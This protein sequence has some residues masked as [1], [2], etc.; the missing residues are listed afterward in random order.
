MNALRLS[1]IWQFFAGIFPLALTMTLMGLTV[2]LA[3][4][5]RL[6]VPKPRAMIKIVGMKNYK[7]LWLNWI[8]YHDYQPSALFH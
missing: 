6:T 5:P 3:V 7:R 4:M 8:N 1:K 2:I